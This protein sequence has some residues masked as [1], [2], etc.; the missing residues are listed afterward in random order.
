[1]PYAQKLFLFLLFSLPVCYA[2]EASQEGLSI[3]AQ[4]YR[5]LEKIPYEKL[6]KEDQNLRNLLYKG[7]EFSPIK[8]QQQYHL[9]NPGIIAEKCDDVSIALLKELFAHIE[10]DENGI[11]KRVPRVQM[12]AEAKEGKPFTQE[13]FLEAERI[14]ATKEN[15]SALIVKQFF[16]QQKALIQQHNHKNFVMRTLSK[17]KAV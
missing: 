9:A 15:P 8:P 13:D 6:T 14:V 1:M 17:F 11:A 7:F 16:A 12:K 3:Y 5:E 2:Q 10:C 4:K